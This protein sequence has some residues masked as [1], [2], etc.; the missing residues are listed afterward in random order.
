MKARSVIGLSGAGIGLAVYSTLEPYRYRLATHDLQVP[1]S[2][3]PLTMLHLSDTHLQAGDRRLISWLEHLPAQVGDVPDLVLA[4]GDMIEN[5]Q[6]IGPV[7]EALSR[8]DARV[9]RFYVLGSHDYFQSTFQAYTKYWT[10]KRDRIRAPRADTRRLIEQL[11]SLGWVNL[12]NT[13]TTVPTEAGLIRL[14]GVDDPY[15]ERHR[16]DHIQRTRAEVAAIGLV[17][18]PDVVSEWILNGFDVVVAGHTHGGQVRIPGAGAVVTNCS[19]PR[20][21]AAGPRRIGAG[22]LHVS[23]GLGTGRFSPIR[24]NCRPEATLLRLVPEEPG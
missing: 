11:D 8:F 5:D 22:W 24:F 15:L 10:G 9:G 4:T 16:T 17:H 18:C 3:P 7:V 20:T 23:P 6:G 13:S 19:L 12:T 1:P 14:S 21:L 2:V